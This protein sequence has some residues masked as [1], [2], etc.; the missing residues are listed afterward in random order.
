MELYRESIN[1]HIVM[2]DIREMLIFNKSEKTTCKRKQTILQ[3]F[4][5]YLIYKEAECMGCGVCVLQCKQQAFTFEIVRPPEH[6]L[7]KPATAPAGLTMN[8]M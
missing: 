3:L 5:L 2:A 4:Q 7:P 8:V 6:I 1:P